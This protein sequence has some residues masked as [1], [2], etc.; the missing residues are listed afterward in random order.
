MHFNVHPLPPK[1]P[2]RHA[3]PVERPDDPVLQPLNIRRDVRINL[4]GPK[5][6]NACRVRGER[7]DRLPAQL[8]EVVDYTLQVHCVMGHQYDDH[9]V[10][11]PARPFDI[12]RENILQENVGEETK[13]IKRA[14]ARLTR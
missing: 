3:T 7:V 9:V 4:W 13:H 12:E 14:H 1:V 6:R 10:C 2:L 5:G 8:P 11:I